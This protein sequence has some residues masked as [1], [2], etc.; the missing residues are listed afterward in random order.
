MKNISIDREIKF[1]KRCLYNVPK[2]RMQEKK[3]VNK[4]MKINMK[5]HYFVRD[6]YIMYQ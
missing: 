3:S 5:K 2:I 6:V 4:N 1:C